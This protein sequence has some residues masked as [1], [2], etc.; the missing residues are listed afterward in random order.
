MK[1]IL[2][3]GL[4]H[5]GGSL[6]LGL[7]KKFKN[8][9]NFY[10]ID[11]SL[12]TLTKSHKKIGFLKK[13]LFGNKEEK[14]IIESS[15]IIFI[16][17]EPTS[18]DKIF[19]KISSYNVKK[20]VI[21]SDVASTKK[22]ILKSARKIFKKKKINF[23][24]GHPIAGTEKNGFSSATS[25]LFEDKIYIQSGEIATKK[26]IG[27]INNLWRKLGSKVYTIDVKSHD[28]VFAYLSHLPHA[29]SFCLNSLALKKIGKK[30]IDNLGGSSY[31]DYSRISSSSSLLWSD[32][33]L[34][35]SS[36]LIASLNESILFL[37][38]LK[39]ALKTNSRS[40]IANLIKS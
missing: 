22:D 39:L 18:I 10:G 27:A 13:C 29:L 21:V 28:K 23:V 34:S 30:R 40:K 1:N 31:K 5:I 16:C 33:F 4:G 14:L 7:K 12:Q 3:I 11:I 25:D 26:Q 32:I 2:I 15:D 20:G 19:T 17:V 8:V 37:E 24:G 9:F 35:N 6:A 36:N 38:K